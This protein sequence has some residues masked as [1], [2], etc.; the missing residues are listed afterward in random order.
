MIYKCKFP[1]PLF[2]K[3][4]FLNFLLKIK[5]TRNQKQMHTLFFNTKSES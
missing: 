2:L 5:T 3:R 1:D 4:E